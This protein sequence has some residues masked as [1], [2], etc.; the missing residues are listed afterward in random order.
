MKHL[1]SLYDCTTEEM[2]KINDGVDLYTE[3]LKDGVANKQNINL[4]IS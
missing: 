3:Y 2:E 4:I 1:L